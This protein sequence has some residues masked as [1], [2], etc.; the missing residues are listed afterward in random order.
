MV[1]STVTGDHLYI[2]WP[3]PIFKCHRGRLEHLQLGGCCV[4]TIF[5]F[6][7]SEEVE[8]VGVFFGGI[9]SSGSV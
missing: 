4:G 1:S 8:A 9:R 6:A 5:E 2:V 3:V 7:T